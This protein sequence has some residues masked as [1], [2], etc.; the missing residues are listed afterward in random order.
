MV[1]LR[2]VSTILSR[3]RE[4]TRRKI[5]HE[6]GEWKKKINTTLNI[7]IPF[8]PFVILDIIIQQGGSFFFDLWYFI[9]PFFLDNVRSFF[10]HTLQLFANIWI[11]LETKKNPH[12]REAFIRLKDGQHLSQQLTSIIRVLR[13]LLDNACNSHVIRALIPARLTPPTKQPS[14]PKYEPLSQLY[15]ET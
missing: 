15:D 7:H 11:L 2:C 10:C 12:E 9:R 3:S 4:L 8:C 6:N 14:S 1:S 13:F 5:T